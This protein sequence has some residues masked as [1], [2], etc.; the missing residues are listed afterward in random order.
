MDIPNAAWGCEHGDTELLDSP[1]RSREPAPGL[2][3]QSDRQDGMS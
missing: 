2:N 3:I 1:R